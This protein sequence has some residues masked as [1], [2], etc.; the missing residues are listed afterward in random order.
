MLISSVL[1]CSACAHLQWDPQAAPGTSTTSEGAALESGAL[2]WW[3]RAMEASPAQRDALLRSA[4]QSK[5]GWRTAM[6]RSLPD[7][8]EST[9][10]EA[11]QEAL[12]VLLHRGLRDEEEALTRVRIVEL[13]QA[14]RCQA[15]AAELRSHLD[16]IIEIERT[17]GNGR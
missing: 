7:T 14:G 9:T 12:R 15:E 10:P 2:A 5:S 17:M 3:A 16:R 11:S 8:A 1:A 13:E 4:R 6:L